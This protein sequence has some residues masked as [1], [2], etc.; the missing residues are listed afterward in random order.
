MRHF[1]VIIAALLMTIC[2][3]VSEKDAYEVVVLITPS[4][5][6]AYSGG[7]VNFDI[8]TWTINDYLTRLE[9]T[10]FDLENGYADLET[11]ELAQ[12]HY[13]GEFFYNVPEIASDSL[14]VKVIFEVWDNLGYSRRIEYPIKVYRTEKPDDELLEEAATS[15]TMYSPASGKPD[16]FCIRTLQT[17]IT[18]AAA[19]SDIDIYLYQEQESDVLPS[20]WRSRTGLK[21]ARMSGVNYS[22]I[23]RGQLR[24]LY[25]SA[26]KSDLVQNV[27][28]GDVILLGR[29]TEAEDGQESVAEAVGII[30][31]TGV[32]DEAGP[33][34]DKYMF[35]IKKI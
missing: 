3:C 28:D 23:T 2:G 35:N 22:T 34:N 12:K 9:I 11:R 6:T 20:E 21:F 13:K 4:S 10:S 31:V 14:S 16:G 33:S 29:E 5:Y 32:Y 18:A 27:E 24:T 26:E 25:E 1:H 17:V 7:N 15:V 30:L 8:N 19:E